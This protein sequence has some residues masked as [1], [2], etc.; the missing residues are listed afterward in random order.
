MIGVRGT[1]VKDIGANP[2]EIFE[3]LLMQILI[4][5]DVTTLKGTPPKK[6][7]VL[8]S[9]ISCKITNYTGQLCIIQGIK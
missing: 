7:K 6:V 4:G 9:H 5:D 8:E 2:V 1:M 3:K